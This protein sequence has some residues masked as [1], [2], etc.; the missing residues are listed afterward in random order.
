MVRKDFESSSISIWK[1]SSVKF[2]FKTTVNLTDLRKYPRFKASS[3]SLPDISSI[4][5]MLLLPLCL[6]LFPCFYF[7]CA[8]PLFRS[9]LFCS[10]GN[11]LLFT[12]LTL[13]KTCFVSCEDWVCF[14]SQFWIFTIVNKLH[15]GSLTYLTYFFGKK[16]K[17]TKKLVFA[18]MILFRWF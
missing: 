5:C 7:P 15:L 6:S 16:K 1:L 8:R 13:G 12:L 2:T 3:L 4:L 14:V 10:R 11:Y 9:L 18:Y 17:Q